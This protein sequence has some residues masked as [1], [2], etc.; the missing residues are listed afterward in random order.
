MKPYVPILSSTPARITL[1]AV[2]ASTC[3]SGSHVWNGNIGTFIANPRKIPQKTSA[4]AGAFAANGCACA[5]LIMLK[6]C[7]PASLTTS[8]EKYIARI[9]SS[10]VMLPIMVY[11]KNLIAAYSLRGPPQIPI[12]KYIGT[13]DTSQNTK[14]STKSSEVNTPSIPISRSRNIQKYSFGL[15]SINTE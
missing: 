6:V 7:P 12:R 15:L 10:I 4:A 5:I 1:P 11:R 14:N 3:A 13:R 2:G 8:G 9:P